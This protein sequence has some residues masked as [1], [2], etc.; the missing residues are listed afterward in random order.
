MKKRTALLTLLWFDA[1]AAILGGIGLMQGKM[2]LPAEWLSH[3]SFTSYYFP[4]V[5]LMAIVGGSSLIAAI[6][7]K[8]NLVGASLTSLVAGIIM[9]LWI[10][11]EIVSIREFHPLQVVFIISSITIIYLTPKEKAKK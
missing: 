11:G 9:L 10:L 4:G 6:A 2:G 8:K 5:I 1:T 3:T 7:T